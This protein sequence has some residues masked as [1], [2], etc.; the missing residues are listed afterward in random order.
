MEALLKRKRQITVK[1]NKDKL[2]G[3]AIVRV[4]KEN[5][6][7]DGSPD[8]QLATIKRWEKQQKERTGKSYEIVNYIIED[9][10]SGRYQ[11]THKRKD[12]LHL[13]DLVKMGAIDFIVAE[14]LN[15]ISRDEVLNLQLMRDARE[16]SVE[17]HE[18]NYGQFNPLDRGQ[19]MGW[20]FRNI[21][22]GEYSEGVSEDVSRKL[23]QAMVHNGKD[24]T[25]RPTLGFD[26]HPKYVGYYEPNREELAI[27][28]DIA[29][30]FVDLNYSRKE[31]IEYCKK[32][33]YK[34]K[35]WWTKEKNKNGEIIK[36]RKM[37]GVDF[38]WQSLLSLLES[39]KIRGYNYFYDNWNMFKE[40]QDN[41][42]WVRWEYRHRRKHGDLVSLELIKQVD[43]GLEK[44][45]RCSRANDFL[46]AGTL[47]APDGSK[48][49]GEVAKSAQAFYYYNRSLSKRFPTNH[50]HKLVLKRLEELLENNNL[51]KLVN[52]VQNHGFLGT[53]KFLERRQ[54]LISEIRRLDEIVENFSQA[55]RENVTEKNENFVEVI[56]TMIEEKNKASEEMAKLK[57]EIYKLEQQEN[58]FKK[59][60]K[61]D[62][63]K[64]FVKTSLSKIKT[65]HPL[66]QKNFIQAIAPKIIIHS[67]KRGNYLQIFYNLDIDPQNLTGPSQSGLPIPQQLCSLD[68][69]ISPLENFQNN[70]S[71]NCNKAQ[72][73][74][75]KIPPET[76][77]HSGGQFLAF[78]QKW[79]R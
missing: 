20:K 61:G 5:L 37:G 33:G 17:L 32:K 2:K 72:K 26:L 7:Q 44:S 52:R 60:L 59:A 69:V 38:N 36:P 63:F 28:E 75:Q 77:S 21:E 47:Y 64:R 62:K 30:K 53:P 4:S 54:Q 41:E 78:D 55:L 19:R 34:T 27:W 67:S 6:T 24:P 9:G 76:G 11:N 48:Y 23:R 16:K 39:A 25:P 46:L 8:Q 74:G 70:N 58:R 42:E 12:L 1:K 79:W 18:I 45:T 3:W 49:Y 65:M 15:R 10:V 57:N 56:E 22:A 51:E 43:K 66:E 14:R 50:I 68:N 73:K 29:K 13:L 71:L 40:F 31:T 35:A